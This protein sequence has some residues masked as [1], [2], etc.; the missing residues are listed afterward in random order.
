MKVCDDRPGGVVPDQFQLQL[1][2]PA[3]QA[4]SPLAAPTIEDAEKILDGF[5]LQKSPPE[6]FLLRLPAPVADL[7]E[8]PKLGHCLSELNLLLRAVL[9]LGQLEREPQGFI[10][11]FGVTFL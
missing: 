2:R 6:L 8:P 5:G 10:H 3:D 9:F 4:L 7:L 11:Y 1:S